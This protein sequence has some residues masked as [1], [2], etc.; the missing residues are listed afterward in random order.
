MATVTYSDL[1]N[2]AAKWAVPDPAYVN[3][4]IPLIGETNA[5]NRADWVR[6]VCNISIRSPTAVLFVN[7]NDAEHL[8]VTH[9]PTVHPAH[10]GNATPFDN[11]M[12]L[13]QGNT[14]DQVLPLCFGALSGARINATRCKR[15]ADITA[16]L[17][18]APPVF[19]TGPHGA[20]V[21][22]TD[23]V[24]VRTMMVLPPSV[25][26][27]VLAAAPQ[28]RFTRVGFLT[29]L[30]APGLADA[31]ADVVAMWRPVEEWFRVACTQGGAP[32]ACVTAVAPV[33]SVVPLEI[34]ALN[35]WCSTVKERLQHQA[36]I[37]GP[38][39]T[40][41]TFNA[42]VTTL[43]DTLNDNATARL[44]FER[45]RNDKSFTQRHGDSLA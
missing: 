31:N 1:F 44:Q 30:L 38:G 9:S 5:V 28:G 23:Q 6:N 4:L 21:A 7:G 40:N 39:L 13:L 22:D 20:A 17:G 45:D 10:P 24:S 37:G 14:S 42:G 2:D 19:M 26:G 41:H 8:Y 43:R 27:R 16:D 36:G 33:T 34:M 18:A 12:I 29:N 3:D 32:V 15:T 11:L 25:A 35:S